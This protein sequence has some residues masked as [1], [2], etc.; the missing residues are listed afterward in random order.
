MKHKR[1]MYLVIDEEIG[2]KRPRDS[3]D[4]YLKLYYYKKDAK[5]ALFKGFKLV[6]CIV[7]RNIKE[8]SNA[9][10]RSKDNNKS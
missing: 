6:K 3:E 7:T 2:L 10:A 1:T 5:K 4:K 8:K 9:K